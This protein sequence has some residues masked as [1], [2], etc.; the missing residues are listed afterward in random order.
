[1]VTAELT[2]S[3]SAAIGEAWARDVANSLRAQTRGVIGGWPG[4]MSEARLR[5][6]V[7]L[8]PTRRNGIDSAALE[9]MSRAVYDAARRCWDAISEPDPEP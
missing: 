5:V 7:G 3:V 6:I 9:A 1:L 2:P 4:T 8:P